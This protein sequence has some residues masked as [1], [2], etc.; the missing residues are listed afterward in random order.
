MNVACMQT[1]DE[2]DNLCSISVEIGVQLRPAA[3]HVVKTKKAH[4]VIFIFT[5][6]IQAWVLFCGWQ[7]Q[8]DTGG[9]CTFFNYADISE[10]WNESG[11][12]VFR[13]QEHKP[14]R[15]QEIG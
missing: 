8:E 2:T 5:W 14:R 6:Y 15:P 7:S 12:Q 10:V 4:C 13:F 9:T 1:C 3:L 11:V